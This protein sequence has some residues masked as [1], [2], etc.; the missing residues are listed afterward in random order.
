[1]IE[2]EIKLQ[3]KI[4]KLKRDYEKGKVPM[5][6]YLLKIGRLGGKLGSTRRWKK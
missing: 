4:E 5:D 3:K 2:E 1:M 6:Q